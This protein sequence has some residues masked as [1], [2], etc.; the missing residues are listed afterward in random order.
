MRCKASRPTIFGG[1][2]SSGACVPEVAESQTASYRPTIFGGRRS[3]QTESAG[4]QAQPAYAGTYSQPGAPQAGYGQGQTATGA[5]PAQ[6]GQP[7]AKRRRPT[8][9]GG[10]RRA[11]NPE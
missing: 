8:I 4:Y 3:P 10:G 5:V 7:K 2:G 9:F 1:G 11:K 6:A